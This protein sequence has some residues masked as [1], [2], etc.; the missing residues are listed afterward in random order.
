[1]LEPSELPADVIS[2]FEKENPDIAVKLVK[3]DPTR[4]TAMLAAG[5]PPDVAR[6]TATFSSY[7]AVR[8]LAAEIDPYLQKSSV[9]K[10]S[11]LAGINDLWRFDGTAQGQGPRYGLTIDYSQDAMLWANT[12][13]FEQAK[14]PVPPDTEP[15]AYENLIDLARKLTRK[16]SDKK[17]AVFGYGGTVDFDMA[18]LAHMV[19]AQS[20]RLFNDDYTRVDFSS[21]EARKTLQFW[22]DLARAGVSYGPTR[23]NPAGWDGTT[24]KAGRI[25]LYTA[26]YWYQQAMADV[27]DLRKASRFLPAPTFAGNRISP[28]YYGTGVWI[29][30]KAKNKDAAWRFIEYYVG[31]AAGKRRAAE[32]RGLPSLK[33]LEG[34]LPKNTPEAKQSY[35]TQRR[36]LEHYSAVVVNTPYLRSESLKKVLQAEFKSAVSNDTAAG[37]VADSLNDQVN[38]LIDQERDKVK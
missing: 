36:E 4:L 37:K 10:E 3:H 38:E 23:P 30:A 29:P 28:C 9:I 24:Y 17:T 20:G 13:L 18:Q 32:G 14:V 27:P 8:G 2:G 16:T 25:A 15:L 19:S 5:D 22:I 7:L 31:G 35:D 33:S 12:K 1:M 6:E 21:P 26:G 34:E 11:D